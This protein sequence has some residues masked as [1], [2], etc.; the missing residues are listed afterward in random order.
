MLKL[1]K[2]DILKGKEAIHDA[3]IKALG[4]TVNLRPLTDGEWSEVKG[5]LT[6]AIYLEIAPHLKADKIE[7][8]TA[9]PED[10]KKQVEKTRKKLVEITPKI[11]LMEYALAERKAHCLASSYGLSCNGE[12][13]TVEEV[14]GLPPGSADEITAIVFELSGVSLGSEELLTS[15]RKK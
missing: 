14:N 9:N 6:K 8:D 10:L 13:W 7:V 4:G 15:F 11:N 3:E 12:K 2:A 5:L 1:T